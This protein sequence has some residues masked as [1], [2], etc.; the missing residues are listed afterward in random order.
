MKRKTPFELIRKEFKL[1]KGFTT[2]DADN[3][4]VGN[5]Y[6]SDIINLMEEYAQQ[7]TKI[8][9]KSILKILKTLINQKHENNQN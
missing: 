3:T 5:V 9:T 1:Y 2:D 4:K 6:I 7:E 8:A